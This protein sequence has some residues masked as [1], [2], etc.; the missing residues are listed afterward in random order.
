MATLLS[1]VL[2]FADSSR[3][4]AWRKAYDLYRVSDGIKQIAMFT[5][6]GSTVI[7]VDQSE[8]A[9]NPNSFDRRWLPLMEHDGHYWGMPADSA[10]AVYE[11]ER[12]R[13]AGGRCPTDSCNRRRWSTR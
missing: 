10:S 2:G 12:L 8:W 13:G 3:T 6:E 11:L 1:R 9:L 4:S 7:L 5:P